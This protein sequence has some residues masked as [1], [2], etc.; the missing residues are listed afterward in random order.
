MAFFNSAILSRVLKEIRVP[1]I[2]IKEKKEKREI[3][4]IYTDK[5]KYA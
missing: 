3:P 5:H 4:V 1:N 2:S